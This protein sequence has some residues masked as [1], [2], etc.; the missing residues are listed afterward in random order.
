MRP[1]DI[2]RIVLELLGQIAPEAP[3][4]ALQNAVPF[5]SQFEFDSIDFLN[6]VL[7]LEKETGSRIPELDYPELSSLD[8]CR[9]YLKDKDSE[10]VA[11]T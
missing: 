3:L 6:F 7:K 8:G 4:D 2:D 10:L 1:D 5:R 11:G 9:A